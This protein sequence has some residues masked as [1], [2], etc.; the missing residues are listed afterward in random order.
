MVGVAVETRVA[1]GVEVGVGVSEGGGGVPVAVGGMT[2]ARVA[3]GRGRV[4]VAGSEVAG[5]ARAG[6]TIDWPD[7]LLAPSRAAATSTTSRNRLDSQAAPVG[8]GRMPISTRMKAAV[9]AASARWLAKRISP[10]G[11]RP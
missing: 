9:T 11:N 2:T 3:L 10:L 8:S 5:G 1:V 4:A 7:A 6:S